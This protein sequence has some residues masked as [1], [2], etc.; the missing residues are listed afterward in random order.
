[1]SI[2]S[3]SR[4]ISAHIGALH[5]E[6]PLDHNG[7][8]LSEILSEQKR[9][10]SLLGDIKISLTGGDLA[11]GESPSGFLKS[12]DDNSLL[13]LEERWKAELAE[14]ELEVKHIG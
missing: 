12:L 6:S 13:S 10:H 5:Q 2:V 9:I 4:E 14:F 8:L 7:I 1:M 3:L 11:I